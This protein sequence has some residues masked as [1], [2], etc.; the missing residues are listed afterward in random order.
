MRVSGRV[1]AKSERLSFCRRSEQDA[2][3][4]RK[5]GRRDVQVAGVENEAKQPEDDFDRPDRVDY[6]ARLLGFF[7]APQ[8]VARRMLFP[9]QITVCVPLNLSRFR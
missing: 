7:I 5:G 1:M 9:F 3:E 8:I 6:P 2:I 4:T